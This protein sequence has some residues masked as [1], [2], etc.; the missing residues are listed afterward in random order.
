M[1]R[2]NLRRLFVLSCFWF[3][4]ISIHAQYTVTGGKGTPLLAAT[5]TAQ[6]LEVYLVYGMQNVEIVFTSSSPRHQWYRYRVSIADKEPVPAE[7]NGNTSV[8]RNPEEGY[9]YFVEEEGMLPHFVWIIDYSKYAFE[10]QSL[11]VA[12]GNCAGMYL[13]GTPEIKQMQYFLPYDGKSRDLEREF[14]VSYQTL[15]YKE[16]D[17]LFSE[18]TVT[19][20]VKGNVLSKNVMLEAPLCD[21]QVTLRGD[22][23]ARHFD[24]EQT[25][26]T[27]VYQA[28]AVFAVA[29]TTVIMDEAP[30]LTNDGG[31]MLSA[32]VDIHFRARANDPVASLFMWTIYRTEAPDNPLVQFLGEEVDYTFTQAGEYTAQL[33]VSDRTGECADNSNVFTIKITDS[34]LDVPNA[35]SPGTTPGIND[36]FR[37]AYKSIV[38]YKCW[39]F[40]RWGVEIYHSTNP[41]AGW[42]GKK[43]GKYV[44]PG[45]YFYVIEAK[46]SD[47]TSW[48]KKGSINILRP[49]TVDE[50]V[51]Q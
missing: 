13:G 19:N 11:F 39:I 21:T 10:L 5:E 23:F 20:K 9:G 49:K 7:Q 2:K 16:E 28:V 44:P 27:E 1:L 42:D 36:E 32:P 6:K 37:V 25:M 48:N 12:G 30:N 29:D 26:T 15:Q 43:G 3:V 34:F 38:S 24:V 22:L 17:K 14:E 51:Q 45:V 4:I 41:A 46:G 35:F 50:E 31:D 8:I 33:D 18:Y 47:G 40:N